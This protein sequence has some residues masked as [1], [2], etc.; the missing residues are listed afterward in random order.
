MLI[1]TISRSARIGIAESSETARAACYSTKRYSVV[2]T[3]VTKR[4][5]G[6]FSVPHA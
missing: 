4:S 2:Y 5:A 1:G 3:T 6:T